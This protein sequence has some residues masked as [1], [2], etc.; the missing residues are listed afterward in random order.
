MPSEENNG[1]KGIQCVSAPN[2]Y[3][4]TKKRQPSQ[5]ISG[6]YSLRWLPLFCTDGDKVSWKLVLLAPLVLYLFAFCENLIVLPMS[7][8]VTQ[9]LLY[10]MEWVRTMAASHLWTTATTSPGNGPLCC[11]RVGRFHPPIVFLPSPFYLAGWLFCPLSCA[12]ALKE[13]V[14]PFPIW[15]H[16]PRCFG[17]LCVFQYAHVVEP[18]PDPLSNFKTVFC[19]LPV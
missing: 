8:P 6:L 10:L 4:C 18:P 5:P 1:S 13:R 11:F 16:S 7:Y 19:P 2:S 17:I 3:N 12:S 15:A 14:P 9:F